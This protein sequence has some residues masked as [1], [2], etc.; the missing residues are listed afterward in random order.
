MWMMLQ[1]DKPDDHVLAAGQ[2]HAVRDQK[3]DWRHEIRFEA[4]IA[5]LVAADRVTVGQEAHR[6]GE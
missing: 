6:R 5:E 1:Q 3:F 2:T 4:P